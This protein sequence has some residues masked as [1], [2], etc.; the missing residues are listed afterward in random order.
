MLITLTNQEALD[1]A[2]LFVSIGYSEDELKIAMSA[3]EH[4]LDISMAMERVEELRK[5]KRN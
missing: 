5:G 1:F 4:G 3:V 2:K